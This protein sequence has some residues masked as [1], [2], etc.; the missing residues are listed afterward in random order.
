MKKLNITEQ[1]FL[2]ISTDED[3]FLTGQNNF[4]QILI[5]EN[6]HAQISFFNAQ[7][8]SLEC[9]ILKNGSLNL[10]VI[11]LEEKKFS[12]KF[13]LQEGAQL[14]SKILSTK[15][16]EE[17]TVINLNEENSKFYGQYLILAKDSKNFISTK[18]SHNAPKTFSDTTN[19]GI[20]LTQGNI[21]F[22][23]VG[24]IEQGKSKSFCKQLT[25]GII[26]EENA[27][28]T[29]QP[30]LLIDEHDVQAHHGVAIGKISDDELFYLMSRGLTKKNS[31]QLIISSIIEPFIENLLV[32]D[33][34]QEIANTIYSLL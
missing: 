2:Q 7:I 1:N 9:K 21:N 33:L 11:S 6:V 3:F 17:E 13:D 10:D 4:L 8:N 28:I 25:R 26:L 15:K 30:I 23:I 27:E 32:K 16:I 29:A 34:K 24:K 5:A 18:I 14:N 19:F 20:A 12:T 31:E 22:E